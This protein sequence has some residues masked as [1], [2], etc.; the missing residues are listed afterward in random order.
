MTTRNQTAF[1]PLKAAGTD[2]ASDQLGERLFQLAFA[3]VQWP[4]LLKSLYGGT[5]ASKAALLEK[6]GLPETA[7]PH[8]GSWKADTFFLH[9]VVDIIIRDRPA[10]VVELGSGASSLV[11]AQALKQNGGG[12][13]VSYDQ[14]APFVAEMSVW[15][16]EYDLHADFIHAPLGVRASP[17][18]GRWYDLSGVPDKIDLLIVD[19]PPWTVHPY[20]RGAA[21]Q[22]FDRLAPDGT[23]LLDD[24]ARP[25]E[26]IITRRWRRDH[27]GVEF[28]LDTGGAKGT[29]IGTA[30]LG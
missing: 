19:G 26:R 9:T 22:L 1:L 18:P 28:H 2:T 17:W 27:P 4:W 30:R 15:L 21:E 24:A 12:R 14:H 13:L 7:L 3:L 6:I 8:L 11:I 20:V 16:G 29:L 23:L 10:V 25:G 5:K